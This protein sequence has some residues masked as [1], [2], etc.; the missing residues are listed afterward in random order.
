V[1]GWVCWDLVPRFSVLPISLPFSFSNLTQTNLNSNSY[2][3]NQ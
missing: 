3:L 1:L 2:A